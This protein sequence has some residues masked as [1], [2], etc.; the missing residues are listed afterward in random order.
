MEINK[1]NLY[2]MNNQKQ[3]KFKKNMFINEKIL[4]KRKT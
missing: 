2:T 3:T 4:L 1:Q